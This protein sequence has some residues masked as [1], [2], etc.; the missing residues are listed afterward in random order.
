MNDEY[1]VGDFVLIRGQVVKVYG[2]EVG[3]SVELFSK[4]DQY[5]AIVRPDLIIEKV[6]PPLPDEPDHEAVVVDHDDDVWR[7]RDGFWKL[8]PRSLGVTWTEL[9]KSHGPLRIFEQTS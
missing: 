5:Q 4:T 9:A 8:S 6:A 3:Y 7:F 2:G 1:K